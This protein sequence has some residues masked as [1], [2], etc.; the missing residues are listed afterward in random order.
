VPMPRYTV[1]PSSARTPRNTT[2]S[3]PRPSAFFSCTMKS[4]R[5]W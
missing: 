1:T 5:L 2:R 3:F 4:H